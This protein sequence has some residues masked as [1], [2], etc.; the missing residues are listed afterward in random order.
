MSDKLHGENIFAHI[1]GGYYHFTVADK[2]R[3]PREVSPP[4]NRRPFATRQNYR[5]ASPFPSFLPQPTS[6]NRSFQ[7]VKLV[8]QRAFL[9]KPFFTSFRFPPFRRPRQPRRRRRF[10]ALDAPSKFGTLAPK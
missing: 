8:L 2:K 9:F 3:R 4:P 6:L 5:G 7:Y 10:D 1:S